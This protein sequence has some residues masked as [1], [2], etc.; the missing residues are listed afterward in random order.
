MSMPET[1]EA[2]TPATEPKAKKAKQKASPDPL[3]KSTKKVL[4]D[5][6]AARVKF[7]FVGK[8]ES[9]NIKGDGT[10]SHQFLFSLINKKGEHRSFLL[11]QSEP[12]RFSAMASLLTAAFAAEKK[13]SIR[14]AANA[15]GPAFAGELEVR[16]K[17]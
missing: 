7:E 2:K 4:K 15:S 6:K 3:S 17:N 1:V 8:V 11:D 10:S 14:T 12:L 16:T 5:K 9:I 13:V